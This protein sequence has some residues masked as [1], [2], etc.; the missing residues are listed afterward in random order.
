MRAT[1]KPP[2]APTT[3]LVAP[4]RSE[5]SGAF[6]LIELLVVI[7]IIA[8]LAG[9]LLPA[10][11]RATSK[12][13]STACL[14]NLKQFQGAWL[15]YV[16]DNN[17][18]LPANISRTVQSDQFNVAL[19]GR[20]PWVL[21]NAQV[22][23]N[24]ANIQA[25]TLYKYLRQPR[26]YSCPTDKS[27]V[28]SP[29]GLKRTRSYSIQLWLNCDIMDGTAAG[30]VNFTSF[31]KHKYTG[32][33]DPPPSQV[34]VVIDENEMTINDGVFSIDNRSYVAATGGGPAPFWDA[35]PGY[36]HNNGANLSF[37]DGHAE[38]HPWRFHRTNTNPGGYT[39]TDGRDLADLE[40]LE[41][42][43]PHAP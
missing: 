26:G 31:N 33:V 39:I 21:G 13:Q 10:F 20:V 23:T 40:W 25:G 22:D 41:Q 8:I 36:R 11:V 1:R 35:F 32:L 7:A 5:L 3:P 16:G 2:V 30:E 19:K 37:A 9:M 27:T 38:N 28:R 6:T 17:D 4:A 12:A 29:R 43:L 34:W 15:L 24:N 18:W 14:N 42:G